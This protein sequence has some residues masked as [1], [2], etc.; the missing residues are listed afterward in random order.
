MGSGINNWSKPERMHARHWPRAH[1]ENIAQDAADAGSRP[2]K[3]LN[4][5]WMIMRLNF[6]R[7]S[8]PVTD[9]DD[10]GILSRPLKHAAAM[11]RQPL[12][13]PPR[14]F[15]GAVCAPHHAENSELSE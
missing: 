7:A 4:E 2:L 11:R 8:P 1:G 10:P 13:M 5:R 3:W 9:V 12:Q 14:R 6:E 15:V